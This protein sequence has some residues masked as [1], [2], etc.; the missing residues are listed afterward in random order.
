MPEYYEVV[1]DPIDLLKIQQKIKTDSYSG[2]NDLQTDIE[3]LVDNAKSFYKPD[4]EEYEDANTLW[5]VFLTQKAKIQ[6]SNGGGGDEEAKSNK[7]ARAVGRPKR[8]STLA[9]QQNGDDEDIDVYEELFA[10]VMTAV[11]ID[12]RPLHTMFQL[13]PSKKLYPE[14]YQVRFCPKIQIFVQN[15]V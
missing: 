10:S 11:D 13:L 15:Y 8:S 2:L 6:E 3:L 7:S 1:S 9:N 4:S 5:E 14:Y 12:D